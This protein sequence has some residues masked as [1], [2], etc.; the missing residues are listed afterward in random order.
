MREDKVSIKGDIPKKRTE[1]RV[2]GIPYWP[3]QRAVCL[4]R[5]IH[6]YRSWLAPPRTPKTWAPDEQAFRLLRCRTCGR[7]LA[8]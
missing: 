8:D 6:D 5:G 7:E 1:R 4:I 3:L 2:L